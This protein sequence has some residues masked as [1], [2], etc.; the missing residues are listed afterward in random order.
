MLSSQEAAGELPQKGLACRL[1]DTVRLLAGL[2]CVLTLLKGPL[3][4]WG[5]RIELAGAAC[6]PTQHVTSSLQ[7]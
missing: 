2:G 7:T 3:F 5:F 6:E 4:V 1:V